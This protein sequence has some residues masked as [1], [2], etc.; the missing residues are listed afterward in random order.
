MRMKMKTLKLKVVALICTMFLSA[1]SIFAQSAD[2]I[3][4]KVDIRVVP[5]DM[6]T[7][8]KMNLID[9]SNQ[10]RQKDLKTYKLSDEKMMMWFLN[11]ADVKGS[12]F[13]KI[14]YDNK[15]D[16]MW[17]YLPALGKVRRVASSAKNGSFMGSDFTY[18][19]M[20]DRKLKDYTYKLLKVEN[21]A[22]KQCWV[23]E[24]TPKSGVSTDY[25]KIISWVWKDDYF[26]MK[27]EFYNKKGTLKKIKTAEL[28]K[29]KS[30]WVPRKFT[31]QDLSANHKTELVFDK[32]EVDTGISPSLFDQNNMTKI[33]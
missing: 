15:D 28:V 14:S 22:G 29:V 10:V 8:M 6:K 25:S 13:L 32:I 27:E 26:Q 17:I 21:Y 11:P 4:K 5:K 23:I 30:Y 16:D 33:Y 12:S 3:M 7:I 9:K 1:G 31:M 19:D 2:E 18:E 20:G 24:S